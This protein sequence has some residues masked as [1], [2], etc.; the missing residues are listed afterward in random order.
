L[1]DYGVQVVL[2]LDKPHK[3]KTLHAFYAHLLSLDVSTG[4]RVEE[5][6]QIGRT[7]ESGNARGMPQDDRHLHFEFRT[8]PLPGLG[9]GGRISPFEVYGQPPLTVAVEVA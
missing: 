8:E 7:G 9:L 2:T 4:Q 3:G 5:G 1:G 6:D